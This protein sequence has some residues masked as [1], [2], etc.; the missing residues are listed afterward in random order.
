MLSWGVEG[1]RRAGDAPCD[2]RG[3]LGH[4]KDTSGRGPEASRVRSDPKNAGT[5]LDGLQNTVRVFGPHFCSWRSGL[6]INGRTRNG[7]AHPGDFRAQ[8]PLSEGPRRV[9]HCLVRTCRR[10]GCIRYL[11]C[12][13][14]L[15]IAAPLSRLSP[16]SFTLFC[17]FDP[18][19]VMRSA[20]SDHSPVPS[21]MIAMAFCL[22]VAGMLPHCWR[23]APLQGG[24][25][26]SMGPQHVHGALPTALGT[27][28]VAGSVTGLTQPPLFFA[29]CQAV[30]S[31]P[32]PLPCL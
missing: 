28:T 5:I 13:H 25:A 7:P 26:V 23:Q 31:P 30:P 11:V 22:L 8:Q 19:A 24:G 2:W 1:V 32:P 6:A 21:G 9:V 4:K 12:G 18:I 17:D 27:R 3:C 10:V 16:L 20:A 15:S 14:L 29:G